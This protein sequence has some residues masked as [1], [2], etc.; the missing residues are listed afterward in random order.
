[1]PFEGVSV[2]WLYSWGAPARNDKVIQK[3]PAT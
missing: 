3:K 2:M 1:M